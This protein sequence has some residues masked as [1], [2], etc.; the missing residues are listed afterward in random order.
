MFPVR[1]SDLDLLDEAML[2][3][4]LSRPRDYRNAMLSL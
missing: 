2:L 1:N 3:I 4:I